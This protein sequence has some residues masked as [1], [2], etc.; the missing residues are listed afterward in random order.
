MLLSSGPG[1]RCCRLTVSHERE[2]RYALYRGK[3]AA[4]ERD[5]INL[6]RKVLT[7]QNVPVKSGCAGASEITA[8]Q[9]IVRVLGHPSEMKILRKKCARLPRKLPVLLL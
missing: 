8:A 3:Q 5:D 4:L 9:T 7:A 1:S 6:L 2:H